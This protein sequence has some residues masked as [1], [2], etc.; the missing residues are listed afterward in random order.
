MKEVS[1]NAWYFFSVTFTIYGIL[2]VLLPELVREIYEA[3]YSLKGLKIDKR[4]IGW[5]IQNI[6]NT[7]ICFLI[8]AASLLILS[9]LKRRS[10][11]ILP[12][13]L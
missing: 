9:E 12:D 5:S 13:F 10:I 1:I 6:R 2:S 8:L 3:Y 7:G 11:L 4:D